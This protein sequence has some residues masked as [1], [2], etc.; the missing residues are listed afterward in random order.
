MHSLAFASSRSPFSATALAIV[1][2]DVSG[3]FTTPLSLL[4]STRKFGEAAAV[5][6]CGEWAACE[7]GG[8]V[9]VVVGTGVDAVEVEAVC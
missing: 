1:A 5:R 3:G 8:G 2:R 6:A 7:A 4:T 9:I